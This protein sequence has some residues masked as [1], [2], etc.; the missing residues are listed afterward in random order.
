M[1]LST[2]TLAF[3]AL[4]AAAPSTYVVVEIDNEMPLQEHQ[5]PSID[6]ENYSRW[7]DDRRIAHHPDKKL[8]ALTRAYYKTFVELDA[9][10]MREMQTEDYTGTDIRKHILSPTPF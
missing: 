6:P 8:L 1:K 5:T 4:A 10:A 7:F 3:A 9:E 2:L